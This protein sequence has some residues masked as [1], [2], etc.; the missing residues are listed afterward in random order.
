[1]NDWHAADERGRAGA[2]FFYD[3]WG[4]ALAMTALPRAAA[5]QQ[6]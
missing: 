4:L 3:L 6:T 2:P 1:M 5:W